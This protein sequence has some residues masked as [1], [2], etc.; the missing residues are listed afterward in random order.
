MADPKKP[1]NVD[2][3]ALFRMRNQQIRQETSDIDKLM[4]MFGESALKTDTVEGYETAIQNIDKISGEHSYNKIKGSLLKERLNLEKS[5]QMIFDEVQTNATNLLGQVKGGSTEG[6]YSLINDLTTSI[7]NKKSKF[8][9]VENNELTDIMNQLNSLYKVN[10]ATNLENVIKM[11]QTDKALFDYYLRTGQPDNAAIIARDENTENEAEFIAVNKPDKNLAKITSSPDKYGGYDP[12]TASNLETRF[13]SIREANSDLQFYTTPSKDGGSKSPVYVPEST[14]FSGFSTSPSTEV[15]PEAYGLMSKH[16]IS[17]I[18][19]GVFQDLQ[20]EENEKFQYT[21]QSGNNVISKLTDP[22]AKYDS[23]GRMRLEYIN[24]LYKYSQKR[25]LTRDTSKI[26]FYSGEKSP[27]NQELFNELMIENKFTTK[28]EQEG[29][30]R[31]TQEFYDEPLQWLQ[32]ADK[33]IKGE[34]KTSS[35]YDDYQMAP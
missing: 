5:N 30:N 14:V 13:K 6:M 20:D 22:D 3:N 24:A 10:E 23:S 15:L 9:Q 2:I 12:I 21:D 1:Q 28:E 29:L 35:S 18:P 16:F 8:N 4:T 34:V 31:F 25:A 27:A 33:L 11:D 32:D 19:P 17:L 26:P 7:N